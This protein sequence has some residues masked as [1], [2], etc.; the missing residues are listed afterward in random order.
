MNARKTDTEQ[1]KTEL[2]NT[3]LNANAT[4]CKRMLMQWKVNAMEHKRMGM[5]TQCRVSY[6]I[7]CW[8]G[9]NYSMK[10][11]LT[12]PTFVQTTPDVT[13][14]ST[15]T[16]SLFFEPGHTKKACLLLCALDYSMSTLS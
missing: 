6:R 9:D 5:Q 13:Q 8:G 14:D 12:T 10:F 1:R 15:L 3:I 4:E 16:I 7:F 11:V 2:L